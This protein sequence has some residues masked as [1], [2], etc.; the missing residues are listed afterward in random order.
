VSSVASLACIPPAVDAD[1]ALSIATETGAG[2]ARATPRQLHYPYY[3]FAFRSTV[4]TL[5]GE[6]ST[7]LRCLVDGRNGHLATSD[8]FEPVTRAVPDKDV[9]DC[10]LEEPEAER[11][12]R[13]F[14]PGAFRARRRSFVEAR[15]EL[16]DGGLVYKPFWIVKVEEGGLLVDGVTGAL[17][18]LSG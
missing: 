12:A 7:R 10:I 16:V 1:G 9:L 11:A 4:R 8:S 15:I 2:P 5:L 3:W 17:L 14:A 18:P 6:S 13:R